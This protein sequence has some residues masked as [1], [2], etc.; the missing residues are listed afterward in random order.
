MNYSG[1]M[2]VVTCSYC[3]TISNHTY[4]KNRIYNCPK[5]HERLNGQVMDAIKSY[6]KKIESK[7][8]HFKKFRGYG[9]YQS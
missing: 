5:C 3:E 1:R 2:V 9:A 7:G 4:W 8:N 6:E